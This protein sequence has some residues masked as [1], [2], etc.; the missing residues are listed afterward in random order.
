MS[1][2]WC[3]AAWSMAPWS[4]PACGAAALALSAAGTARAR[5]GASASA[6]TSIADSHRTRA[7][8]PALP[9]F[10]SYAALAARAPMGAIRAPP[11]PITAPD[12]HAHGRAHETQAVAGTRAGHRGRL[13]RDTEDPARTRGNVQL[14]GAAG[15]VL[16]AAVPVVP[17]GRQRRR[18]PRRALH[19]HRRRRPV[20]QC[21]RPPPARRAR[22]PR[23]DRAAHQPPGLALAPRIPERALARS[24]AQRGPDLGTRDR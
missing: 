15:R 12:H 20:H 11:A 4:I 1:M 13:W 21:L 2:P 9:V 24:A 7:R 19:P 22:S 8:I 16:A 18:A 3:M 10:A 5:A 17:A 14:G 23:R 6:T